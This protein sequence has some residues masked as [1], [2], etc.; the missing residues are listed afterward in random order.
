MQ[1]MILLILVIYSLNWNCTGHMIIA[2]I[3]RNLLSP[4]EQQKIDK[5][6]NGVSE[7]DSQGS[8]I[9]QSCFADDMSETGL[10][11]MDAEHFY[12]LPIYDTGMNA[13]H[14]NFTP[15]YV[16]GTWFLENA[17][18]SMKKPSNNPSLI[19]GVAMKS[20]LL[21]YVI[22][23]VGD[24]HQPF[25]TITRISKNHKAGDNGGFFFNIRFSKSIQNLHQLWDMLMNKIPPFER[26]L[27]DTDK[28][29]LLN[30]SNLLMNEYDPSKLDE[31]SITDIELMA[32]NSFYYAKESG[33]TLKEGSEP[34]G[35]YIENSWQIIKKLI[36]ISAY[37]LATLL[38]EIST[39]L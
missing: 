23:I 32:T 35:E 3:A 26:P 33:Y 30:V 17:I 22:H 38:K 6:L 8:M 21:R 37:R 24:M 18:T 29:K 9:E 25:H 36:V 39:T 7:H 4:T 2:Q 5:L 14:S 34:S 27:S 11:M 16:N 31:L 28:I 12:F 13:S 1:L 20:L 10:R 19:P 15:P